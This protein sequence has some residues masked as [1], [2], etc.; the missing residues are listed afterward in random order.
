MS[1]MNL[2][3]S[4]VNQEITK[5]IMCIPGLTS[6][7]ESTGQCRRLKRHKKPHKRAFNPWVWKILQRRKWRP[8]PVFLPGKSHEQRKLVGNSPRGHKELDMT[9]RAHTHKHTHREHNT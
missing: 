6:G 5:Y 7:K 8:T 4:G 1:F 2:H 3:F 9:K